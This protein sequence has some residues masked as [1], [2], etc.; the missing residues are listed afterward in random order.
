[1]RRSDHRLIR[2]VLPVLVAALLGCTA[3]AACGEDE[4]SSA[5]GGE[6]QG[7]TANGPESGGNVEAAQ[8]LT[9]LAYEG[10]WGEP[11]TDPNPAAADKL[12]WVVSAGQAS[13]TAAAIAAGME[14]A[15]EDIGWSSKVCD[16]KLDP[17]QMT[18]CWEDALAADPDGIVGI[19]TD[20]PVV[21]AQLEK[22]KS[23]GIETVAAFSYDCDEVDAGPSLFSTAIDYGDR[24]AGSAD[25]MVEA[26]RTAAAWLVAETGG[27]PT[28]LELNNDEFFSL[29]FYQEGFD[30]GMDEYCPDCERVEQTYL[31][32]DFGPAL[33][34]KAQAALTQ[35]PE[36]SA[37][38]ATLNPQLGPIQAVTKVN[39]ELSAVGGLGLAIDADVIREG[40]GLSATVAQPLPWFAYAAI[41]TLNSA[42][43]GE[44]PRDSGIGLAIFDA[45]RNLPPKG[46]DFH[47]PVEFEAA[48]R[49]SWAR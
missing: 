10:T 5:S 15:I 9:D 3:L 4:D 29:A 8:E 33:Q 18:R 6:S 48:Y 35:N 14:G 25:M 31:A 27:D 45:E 26:G 37:V 28:T 38:Q 36:I 42:F 20:C 1:M 12:V 19:S 41:D 17:A 13:P 34:D 16:G 7:S 2:R 40:K 39:P 49:E 23:A 11:P 30:E 32:S 47:S 43:N 24:Y 46:E 22:A 44:E 21:K